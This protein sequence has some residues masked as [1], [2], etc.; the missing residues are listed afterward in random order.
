MQKEFQE[1][2]MYLGPDTNLIFLENN[3]LEDQLNCKDYLM[4][5]L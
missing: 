2:E 4:N 1:P 3:T 5:K